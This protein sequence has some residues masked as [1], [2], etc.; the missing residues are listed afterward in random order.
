MKK[1]PFFGKLVGVIPKLSQYNATKISELSKKYTLFLSS[2]HFF[3]F[4]YHECLPQALF[5]AYLFAF[6][7][8]SDEVGDIVQ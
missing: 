1:R 3:L 4:I 8:V 7:K 2:T 5:S 6:W